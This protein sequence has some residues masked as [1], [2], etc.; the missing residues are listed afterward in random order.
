MVQGRGNVDNV[1]LDTLRQIVSILDVMKIVQRRG[2]HLHD[3]SD[4]KS[5]TQTLI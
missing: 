4:D 2:A 5:I 3:V 1:I